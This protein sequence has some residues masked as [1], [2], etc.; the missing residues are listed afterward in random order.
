MLS[1][2]IYPP[3]LELSQRELNRLSAANF[4]IALTR[5]M[6][7]TFLWTKYFSKNRPLGRFFLVVATSVYISVFCALSPFHVI[8]LRGRTGVDRHSSKN[9]CGASVA[10][11]WSPK[12]EGWVQSVHRPR[13]EPSRGR[14]FLYAFFCTWF[15]RVFLDAFLY[16]F[17]YALLYMFFCTVLLS[18]SVERFFVSRMRDFF[19]T[20]KLFTS[21]R[22]C[23]QCSL[24]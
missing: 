4:A 3:Y 13:V 9:W 16:A 7:G 8:L 12:N 18:A 22:V 17:L 20:C 21:A 6:L 24:T 15:V 1:A 19:S 2:S 11:A 5:K 23:L 14:V 10:H